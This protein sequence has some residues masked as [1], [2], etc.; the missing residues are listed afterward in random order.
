ME[1][2]DSLKFSSFTDKFK[3]SGVFLEVF[4][5]SVIQKPC[6]KFATFYTDFW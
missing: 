5:V 6:S 4:D 2:V 3:I 1:I